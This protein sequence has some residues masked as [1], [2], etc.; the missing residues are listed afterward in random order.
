MKKH[1]SAA[2]V[3]KLAQADQLAARGI[4]Q[5]LICKQLGISVMTLHRWRT[6]AST[7]VGSQLE[8]KLM[9]EN[10]RLRNVAASLLL[11]IRALEEER[12]EPA[13]SG[14]PAGGLPDPATQREPA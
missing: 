12:D 11:E 2:I 3:E 9:V 8:Q 13:A 7:S 1:S 10:N 14:E 4:S 6:R 5:G